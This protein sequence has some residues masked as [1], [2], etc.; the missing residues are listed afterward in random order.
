METIL[1]LI[2]TS[3]IATSAICVAIGW[4]LIRRRRVEAHKRWM[5]AAAAL[6]LT[7]F[8]T[9]LSRTV[10]IGSA[11]FGGPAELR[12]F[13][14]AFLVFH[15]VLAT[16][17]AV[18]GLVTLAHAFRG[19]FDKHRRIGPL[20][21]VIWFCSAVSGVLVYLLLYVLYPSGETIPFTSIFPS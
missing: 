20:T 7:F 13:Y 3:F 8:I 2:S 14:Y 18:F 9:Y 17:A 5:I 10:F 15:I 16:V 21:S 19:Q 1:P 6:A 4:I 12:A 11:T